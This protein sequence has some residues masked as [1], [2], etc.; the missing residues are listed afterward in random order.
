LEATVKKV[1][2]PYVTSVEHICGGKPIIRGTRTSV[3]SIVEYIKKLKYTPDQIVEQLPHLNLAQ[4]YYAL[5]YY[6]DHKGEMD[7]IIKESS[8]KNL[9]KIYPAEKINNLNEDQDLSG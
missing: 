5:S 7:Q 9:K 2:H 8:E 1:E 3:Q 4:V 6:Y